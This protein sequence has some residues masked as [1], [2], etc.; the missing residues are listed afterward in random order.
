[1]KFYQIDLAPSTSASDAMLASLSGIFNQLKAKNL[2]KTKASFTMS[3][4]K[5]LFK[6]ALKASVNSLF[7]FP[8]LRGLRR[9]I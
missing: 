7:C 9:R 1:M 6:S 8:G 2:K 3:V 5:P 4:L